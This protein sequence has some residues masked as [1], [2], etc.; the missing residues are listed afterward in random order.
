MRK[1]L[2]MEQEVMQHGSKKR[3]GQLFIVQ[4]SSA[5]YSGFTSYLHYHYCLQILR[6]R[7][8]AAVASLI[9]AFSW[10]VGSLVHVALR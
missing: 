10:A 5:L 9:S 2:G 4:F 8:T 3:S 7:D 1:R 6:L